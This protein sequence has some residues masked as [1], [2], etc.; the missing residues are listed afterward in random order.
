MKVPLRLTE[1]T[2]LLSLQERKLGWPFRQHLQENVRNPT[3]VSFRI[4]LALPTLINDYKIL[5]VLGFVQAF[6]I[7]CNNVS[8]FI[9]IVYAEIYRLEVAWFDG[10]RYTVPTIIQAGNALRSCFAHR[11]LNALQRL[12][13]CPVNPDHCLLS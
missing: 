2:A 13:W 12:V 11:V 3:G 10:N 7:P 4:N 6:L 5:F 1:L 8:D 9:R